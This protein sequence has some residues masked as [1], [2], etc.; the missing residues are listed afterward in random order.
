MLV[1][2]PNAPSH[3]GT[4]ADRPQNAA[5]SRN[6]PLRSTTHILRTPGAARDGPARCVYFCSRTMMR[7]SGLFARA[8]N[9]T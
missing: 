4:L 5:G 3:Y 1:A 8:S 2:F 6:N 7:D 9:R